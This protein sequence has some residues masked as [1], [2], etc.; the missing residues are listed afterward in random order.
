MN[1]FMLKLAPA[2]FLLTLFSG[3]QDG[4]IEVCHIAPE[5]VQIYPR[6]VIQWRPLPISADTIDPNLPGIMAKNA[7]GYSSYFGVAV[8]GKH[9][10]PEQRI[11]EKTGKEYTF[12]PRG[13]AV[14]ASWIT[15]LWADVDEAGPAGYTRLNS[16]G[17]PPSIIVSSGG[18][19]H[20]YWMLTRPLQIT[21]LNRDTVKR[22]LKG[23][24]KALG[25]DTTVADL[26]RVLRLPGTIN[27]KPSRNGAICEVADYIPC[28]VDYMDM[29]LQFAPLIPA[30]TAPVRR[31]LSLN[32][33]DTRLPKW[34]ADY[35]ETG[36]TTLR[37]KTLYSVARG[38]FDIGMSE[39]EVDNLAGTRA[40]MDGLDDT[41]VSRTIGSAARAPRSNHV[42]LSPQMAARMASEDSYQRYE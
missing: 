1:D 26:A 29:E 37:N 27:T 12:H 38:M 10:P 11:S 5:G 19:W 40:R 18:G 20:G 4:W 17:Y 16:I 31:T 32:A 7:A 24:A 13:K 6:T 2:E 28:A 34:I 42:G 3:V 9:Y 41:E 23:M 30:P 14:D 39:S 36:A 33:I 25:S 21:D 15:C 35:L 8:R 22:T